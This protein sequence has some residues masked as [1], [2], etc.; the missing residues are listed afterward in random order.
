VLDGD[1][2][3]AL[4]DMISARLFV[5]DHPQ[6]IIS[7]NTIVPEEYVIAMRDKNF[8]LTAEVEKAL[9]A[10]Q[11]DGTLDAILARWLV[12]TPAPTATSTE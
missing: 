5:N 10:M 4:V 12:E 7:S 1:A 2:D 3:A 9:D 6:L 8:R 11:A